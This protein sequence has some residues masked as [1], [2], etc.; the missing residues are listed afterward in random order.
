MR[1]PSDQS[2]F[3]RG[4]VSLIETL[5]DKYLVEQLAA[6]YEFTGR[7]SLTVPEALQV[8]EELEKIDDLRPFVAEDFVNALLEGE[9]E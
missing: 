5:G 2:A 9:D 3:A 6:K 1:I 7:E 4:L 8:K